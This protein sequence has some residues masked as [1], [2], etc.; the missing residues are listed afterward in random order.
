M[1]TT[2]VCITLALLLSVL[3]ACGQTEAEEQ[4]D[5]G[6][7][8]C[9][10]EQQ[11][12]CVDEVGDVYYSTEAPPTKIVRTGF[13]GTPRKVLAIVDRWRL[14]VPPESSA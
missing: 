13:A 12:F 14:S 2:I 9:S 6:E 8:P 4:A 7:E 11:E 10:F 5:A 3:A 1:K